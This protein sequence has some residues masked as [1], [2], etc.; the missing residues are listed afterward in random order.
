MGWPARGSD[1]DRHGGL[2][3]AGL[4][5]SDRLDLLDLRC[6]SHLAR[7]DSD[8]ARADAADVLPRRR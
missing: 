5:G 4:T 2:Q 6:E 1:R 3:N 8:P 7:G